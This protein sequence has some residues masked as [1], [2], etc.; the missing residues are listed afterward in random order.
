MF[1]IQSG[2][3]TKFKYEVLELFK[4]EKIYQTLK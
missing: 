1:E 3:K 4:T 2:G